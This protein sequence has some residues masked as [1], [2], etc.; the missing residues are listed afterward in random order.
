MGLNANANTG[1]EAVEV[2]LVKLVIPKE[3]LANPDVNRPDIGKRVT[4]SGPNC[5]Y[6]KPVRQLMIM[7]QRNVAGVK[8][9]HIGERGEGQNRLVV[10]HH[11]LLT[12]IFIGFL[13]LRTGL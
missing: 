6:E 12:K 3:C 8:Y 13:T 10:L 4:I 7:S 1:S 9:R 5:R 2:K 11:P